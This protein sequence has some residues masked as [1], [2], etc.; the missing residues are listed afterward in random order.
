[1]VTK[2]QILYDSI[3]ITLYKNKTT[4]KNRLPGIRDRKRVTVKR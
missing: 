3:Y 1:M 4:V 2:N